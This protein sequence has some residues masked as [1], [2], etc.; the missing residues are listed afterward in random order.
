MPHDF[1][2]QFLK[3]SVGQ[4]LICTIF[5]YLFFKVSVRV[6]L[7]GSIKSVDRTMFF[8]S[9]HIMLLLPFQNK[10]YFKIDS[11]ANS[12]TRFIQ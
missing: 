6:S 12:K 1:K 4:D 8:T 9:R 2:N 5:V 3:I 10:K 11:T 7:S